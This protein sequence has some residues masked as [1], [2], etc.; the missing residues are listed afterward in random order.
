MRLDASNRLR[1][2]DEKIT[3]ELNQI[4][5]HIGT[6]IMPHVL[7][8]QLGLEYSQGLA[9]IALLASEGL[10]QAE[11]LVYHNC[12]PDLAVAAVPLSLGIPKLPWL[13]PECE[14][15]IESYA[16]LAFDV[17]ALMLDTVEVI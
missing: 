11:I 9:I 13:C 3:Q 14:R 7:E 16:E 17:R 5:S 12:E 2:L 1:F 10:C 15:V 6:S 4:L 8:V